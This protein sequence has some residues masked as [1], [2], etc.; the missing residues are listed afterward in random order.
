VLTPTPVFKVPVVLLYKV[1]APTA[2]LLET[3]L[4]L[5]A[6]SPIAILLLP[7]VLQFKVA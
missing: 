2:V 1:K 3:V 6:L 5:K 4:N 7:V